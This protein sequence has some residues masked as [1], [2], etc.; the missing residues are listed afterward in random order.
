MAS[1]FERLMGDDDLTPEKLQTE[2]NKYKEAY[3]Q[4]Y[5]SSIESDPENIEEYTQ[6]FFRSNVHLA[7]GQIMHLAMNADSETVRASC[8]KFVL[9]MALK[10]SMASG[11]PVREM[12]KQ[13]SKQKVS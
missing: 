11:D 2:L 5:E 6:E 7:A 4:E 10:E 13:L 3:Q 8:S 9:D 1:E 12:L